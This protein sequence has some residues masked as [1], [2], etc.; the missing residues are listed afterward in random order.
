MFE[1]SRIR[2][3]IAE[4]AVRMKDISVAILELTLEHKP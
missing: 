4:R 2:I 1:I 3:P